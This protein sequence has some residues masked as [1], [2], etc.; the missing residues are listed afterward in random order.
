MQSRRTFCLATSGLIMAYADDAPF[1]RSSGGTIVM[2]DG[3]NALTD[4]SRALLSWRLKDG[5]MGAWRVIGC[6][7]D[8]GSEV[9]EKFVLA[10]MVMAGNVF[11]SGRL[12]KDPSYSF[13]ILASTKRHAIVREFGPHAGP[14]DTA[15][16]NDEVFAALMIETPPLR[17][18]RIEMASFEKRKIT[19]FWPV[20]ARVVLQKALGQAWVLDFPVNHL[21]HRKSERATSF[22]IET[23]PILVP[24]TLVKEPRVTRIG[25]FAL[26]YAFFNRLDRIDLALFGPMQTSPDAG[27]R[28]VHFAQLSVVDIELYG[29]ARRAPVIRRLLPK[30]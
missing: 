24:E 11:G 15:A 27:R 17:A 30:S 16:E 3:K 19:E 5:T 14:K 26:A 4:F 9:S 21:S 6:A 12:P 10:P 1:A 23:G 2:A 22:Q 7:H 29:R 13:Q 8:A 18:P 28:Y 20:T 25:G